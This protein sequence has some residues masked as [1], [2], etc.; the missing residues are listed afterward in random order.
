MASPLCAH[1]L[2]EKRTKAWFALFV[3][4]GLKV[5]EAEG[6]ASHCQ[7]VASDAACSAQMQTSKGAD[8]YSQPHLSSSHVHGCRPCSEPK[9]GNFAHSSSSCISAMS[10]RP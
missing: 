3:W 1:V 5:A 7:Q 2:V 4:R 10:I 6:G 9:A 8:Q